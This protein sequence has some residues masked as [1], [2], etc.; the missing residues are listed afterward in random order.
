MNDRKLTRREEAIFVNAAQRVLLHG[1]FPNPER[2]GC[3]DKS[4]LRAIAAH[5]IRAEHLMDSI[6]HVG[7]CSPC[8]TEFSAF[9]RQVVIRERIRFAA[10]AAC[11]AVVLSIGLW[12]WLGRHHAISGGGEAT[13][14]ER[15]VTYQA[16]RV[17][18]RNRAALRGQ[19]P[20]PGEHP[21]ELPRR[22]LALSIYL[23][24]GSEAGGYE[25]QIARE[26][27]KPSLSADGAAALHEGIATLNVN[28]NI[29]SL[30]AGSYWAGI[31]RAGL[32]WRYY[33]VI[34]K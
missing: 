29:E 8:Y 4:V 27:G 6:E 25:F 34:I 10:I 14:R 12:H 32:S 28:V 19:T 2:T 16:Y 33:P 22:P 15:V 17:D 9:R 30:P 3:P 5:T 24:L 1:G 18:L 31:R 13:R 21:I 7:F 20:T 11:I 23:P 26:R